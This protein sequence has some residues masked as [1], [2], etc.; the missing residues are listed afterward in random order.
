M[1]ELQKLINVEL[2]FLLKNEWKNDKKFFKY[3]FWNIMSLRTT[4]MSKL[5]VWKY[6]YPKKM[7][8]KIKHFFE[9]DSFK[10]FN[11][12]VEKRCFSMLWEIK[13]TDYIV[14]DE[15]DI[16]KQYSKKLEW[17]ARV[18]DWSP[19]NIVSWYM[20]HWASI[21]CIPVILVQEK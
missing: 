16:A 6:K 7:S 10:E 9:K 19:W 8:E 1:K 4:I 20:F 17:L 3:F 5:W 14:F 12:K 15:V 13:N 18:R 21:N 2:W 11:L